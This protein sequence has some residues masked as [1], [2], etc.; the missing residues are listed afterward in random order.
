M[1]PREFA[2]RVREQADIVRIISD[3]VALRKRGSN[4]LALCPFHQERTPSFAV[5]PVKQIF[6]CFG[7]GI[8]GDVFKFIMQIEGC[9]WW[10]AV[11]LVAEKMGI[12]IPS[13]ASREGAEAHA[14]W[15]HRLLQI[16][17]W[18]CEFFERCLY[19]PRGDVARAYLAARGV[20][21]ETIRRFRLGYAPESWTALT[22]YLLGRRV[23]REELERSGLVIR[24][25]DGSGY[26]DRFRHRLIFPI[27]DLQ[28]RI[29]GFGGRALGSEEPKY[30]NS[31]ETALYAKGRHLFG[32]FEA[33]EAIRR[34]GYAVLVEGY[35]DWLTLFEHGI[36]HSV[37][38]LGTALTEEQVRLLR[39][40]TERIVI[41]FDADAAGRRAMVRNLEPALRGGLDVA[42]LR[43]PEGDDPDSFVR[44]MGAEAYRERLSAATPYLD[45][46]LDEALADV[47]LPPPPSAQAR[48]L[49]VILPYVAG[50]PDA[51]ERTASADRVADRLGMDA[52]VVREEV[53]R[54]RRALSGHSPSSPDGG[55]TPASG[56]S[57]QSGGRL[58]LVASS[59]REREGSP[60]HRVGTP[61]VTPSERLLLEI[62]LHAD[63]SVRACVLAEMD[64]DDVRDLASER[65]FA[66]VRELDPTQ[67]SYTILAERLADD[68]FSLDLVERALVADVSGT[69]DE[70]LDRARRSLR[71]LRRRRLERELVALQMEIERLRPDEND[72]LVRLLQRKQAVAA[73]LVKNQM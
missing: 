12:P 45:F 8:G 16:T 55:G 17:A 30:L 53:R 10:E 49:R 13:L 43:L 63:A 34:A 21:P 19:E 68:P 47:P 54:Y 72:R 7:C 66:L 11:R 40:Y 27:R 15:R 3:Y 32:L 25:E 28:G 50:I 64:P 14:A 42:L 1:T 36:E 52:Q 51:V 48:V 59:A 29:V 67:V 61:E 62:L 58:P 56:S 71:G 26:Y 69:S 35:F 24:R 39:R 37:A 38:T 31:P 44:R 70:L 5:H 60:S 2:E 73:A 22:E 46:L 6:K 41:N 23:T 4:Y 9:S 65:V 20:R 33:R 57:E 18:A